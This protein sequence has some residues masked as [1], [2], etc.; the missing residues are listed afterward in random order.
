MRSPTRSI[1]NRFAAPVKAREPDWVLTVS[2]P[3]PAVP[4]LDGAAL[5]GV[6]AC[7]DAEPSATPEAEE[8][9]A[10]DPEDEVDPEET[11]GAVPPTGAPVAADTLTVNDAE[12]V[13][14]WVKS[15]WSCPT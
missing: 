4:P 10:S 6:V 1:A 2:L 15:F 7:A 3:D 13:F 5:D 11:G 12:N 9:E 8:L 14:G